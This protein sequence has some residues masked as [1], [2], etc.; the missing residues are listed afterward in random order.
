MNVDPLNDLDRQ[1]SRASAP[2]KN[3][4]DNGSSASG[5]NAEDLDDMYVFV[6]FNFN[7]ICRIQ[8]EDDEEADTNYRRE[9]NKSD[10][11]VEQ[12]QNE[13][14]SIFHDVSIS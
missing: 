5:S 12:P 4:D 11:K 8:D 9:R 10:S 2:R 3:S 14:S 6:P 7:P 1:K 13:S